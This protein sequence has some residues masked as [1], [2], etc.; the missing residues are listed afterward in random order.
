FAAVVGLE[1][2]GREDEGRSSA[3]L[4]FSSLNLSASFV[5]ERKECHTLLPALHLLTLFLHV[6]N[7]RLLLERAPVSAPH[8]H[9]IRVHGRKDPPSAANEQQHTA[10]L[11]F[12]CFSLSHP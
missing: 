12:P 4:S 11:H 6:L 5:F 3:I 2:G 8:F 9:R 7:L 1:D 10:A